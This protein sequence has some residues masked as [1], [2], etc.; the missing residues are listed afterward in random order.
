VLL[1]TG[2][3]PSQCQGCFEDDP[4][5]CILRQQPKICAQD[6]ESLG[7]THCGSAKIKY[8]DNFGVDDCVIRGCIDCAGTHRLYSRNH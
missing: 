1:T 5:R 3:G 8:R 2:A 7:T 4:D 6:R